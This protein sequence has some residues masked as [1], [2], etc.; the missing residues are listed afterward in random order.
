MLTRV[1][2][3][4]CSYTFLLFRQSEAI[5]IDAQTFITAN[6]SIENFSISAFAKQTGLGNPLGG[7]FMLVAP[8]ANSSTP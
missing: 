2:H 8:A 6:T 3:I 7:S 5:A 4:L 1:R